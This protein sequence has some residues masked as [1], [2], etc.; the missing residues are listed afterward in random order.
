MRCARPGAG[1]GGG[2]AGFRS[3]GA[4]AGGPVRAVLAEGPA[5][6]WTPIRSPAPA[7]REPRRI[8]FTLKVGSGVSSLPAGQRV[9][10][11]LEQA[12]I[13]GR[14][15]YRLRPNVVCLVPELQPR[16]GAGRASEC[17]SVD[18]FPEVSQPGL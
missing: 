2:L 3:E 1:A 12:K 9:L 11:T 13:W 15:L 4:Y 10:T 16:E 14:K 6:P 8:R 18:T 17:A 5:S 7:C